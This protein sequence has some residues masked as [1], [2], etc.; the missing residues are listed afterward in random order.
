MKYTL[1]FFIWLVVGVSFSQQLPQFSQFINN[2]SLY[3]PSSI[4]LD[5]NAKVTLGGRWQMLGFGS[6]PRTGF[7]DGHFRIPQKKKNNFNPALRLGE[8]STSSDTI[9]PLYFEHTI[10]GQVIIDNYGAFNRTSVN[11]LYSIGFP[12]NHD[13]K[14]LLGTRVGFSNFGFLSSKAQVLNITDPTQAYQGGD[15]EYDNYVSDVMN[16]NS[17]DL[18]VGISILNKGFSFCVAAHQLTNSTLDLNSNSTVYFNQRLH[19]NMMMGYTYSIEDFISVQGM[20]LV[21]KMMPSPLSLELCAKAIF[22][23]SLWAGIHYRNRASVGIMGG[24]FINDRF[25]LGYSVDFTTNR[26]RNFTNGGHELIISYR[27][28]E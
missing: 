21:K 14:A 23:N 5:K 4:G 8:D 25:Q 13:W 27:F 11:G 16:R 24:V 6:E 22:Q 1:S 19:W 9:V 28:G 2:P 3:N 17:F 20:M 7:I 18:G 12:L 10:G 15:L 26:I